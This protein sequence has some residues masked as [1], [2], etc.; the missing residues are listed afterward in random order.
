MI[1][2]LRSVMYLRGSKLRGGRMSAL[3]VF[4][5]CGSSLIHTYPEVLAFPFFEFFITLPPQTN[6]CLTIEI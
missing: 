4:F 5:C 3:I 1:D 6:P 2:M